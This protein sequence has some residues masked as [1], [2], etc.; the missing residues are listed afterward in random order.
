MAAKL[1]EQKMVQQLAAA[2]APVEPGA[3]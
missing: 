2:L 1:V 3:A